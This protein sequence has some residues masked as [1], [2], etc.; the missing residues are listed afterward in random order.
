MIEIV[1]L[2]LNSSY[3]HAVHGE[4][5]PNPDAEHPTLAEF[6]SRGAAFVLE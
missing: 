4:S 5:W 3:Y 1:C 6:F 2:G